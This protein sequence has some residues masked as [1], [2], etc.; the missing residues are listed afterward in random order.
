MLLFPLILKTK[1]FLDLLSLPATTHFPQPLYYIHFIIF[2][3]ILSVIYSQFFD[4]HLDPLQWGLSPLP[5]LLARPLVASACC[6]QRSVPRPYLTLPKS[7]MWHTLL[8]N[9][10]FTWHLRPHSHLETFSGHS[11]PVPFAV[12]SFLTQL[13]RIG[14]FQS[15]V[16]GR[17][18]CLHTFPSHRIQSHHFKYHLTCLLQVS[19]VSL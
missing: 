11:S 10:F 18:L 15:S 9:G 2:N 3:K 17:R 16:L 1:T 13:L 19:S 7:S 5:L 6:F 4:F 12:S 14:M 8:K